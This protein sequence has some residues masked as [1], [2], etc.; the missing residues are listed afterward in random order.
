MSRLRTVMG[1]QQP[2][3]VT[4]TIKTVPADDDPY[5]L[6]LARR[7]SKWFEA[8]GVSA[9]VLPMASEELFRQVLVNHEFDLF[10]G[11]YPDGSVEPD[12]LYSLLH[13]RFSVEPGWQNPFGYANLSVDDFLDRQRTTTGESRRTTVANLQRTLAQENPFTVLAFPDVIRTARTDRFEGF[14]SADVTTATGVLALRQVDP[15]AETLRVTSTD[16]QVTSN[17]NPLLAGLRQLSTTTGLLYDSLVRRYRGETYPWLAESVS[18]VNDGVVDATLRP[19][20]TFHDG[21]PLTAADV[22]FT[23][24]F[25]RDTSLGERE[26]SRPTMGYRG[27]STLVDSATA[28]DRRTVRLDVGDRSRAVTPRALTVPVLPRHVWNERTSDATVGGIDLGG[29][30]TEALVTNNV[31]PVG[32]GPLAFE[33]ATRNDRVVLERFD[34]HFLHREAAAPGVPGD[35]ADGAAFERFVVRHVGSD[36]SAV[37]L[38]ASGEADLTLAGVGSDVVRQIGQ[39]ND[40]D[41]LVDRSGSFYFVGFNTRRAP[42]ANPRFRHLLARLID[43]THLTRSTFSTF[44]TPAISPLAGTEWV[45]ERLAWSDRDPVAPFLGTAGEVDAE[46]AR[47]AFREAGYRY[48]E[49]GRLLGV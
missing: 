38:V 25:L 10:V 19:D 49:Q 3:P 45:P 41:L 37:D 9:Q 28:I 15:T 34:D 31:P 14:D 48:D 39:S 16:E 42:Y 33:S 32:S 20:L 47:A 12:S 7:L 23:F 21:E 11:R 27:R 6:L 44:A 24:E 22:A 17:L 8:A 1:R 40:L 26:Q 18:W 35:L 46:Q 43:R 29:S 2:D 5:A 30:M 4:V 36:P 13:S